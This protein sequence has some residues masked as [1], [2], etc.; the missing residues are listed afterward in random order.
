MDCWGG[1]TLGQLGNGTTNDAVR[2]VSAL[3]PGAG[4]TAIAANGQH[5]CAM[6][7]D[8]TV[9]CWGANYDG[10]NGNGYRVLSTTPVGVAGLSGTT[11]TAVS[12]D[13]WHSCVL[14]SAG[15]VDCWGYNSNG[16]LG[17]GT[18]TDSSTPG[19]VS[20]P[21]TG[22]LSGVTAIDAGEYYNCALLSDTT[23]DCW[24]ANYDGQLGNNSTTDSSKPVAVSGLT[25]VTAIS[26][27]DEFTCA[28]LGTGAVW[29]WG[30]NFYGQ[31][32]NGSTTDSH[33]PVQVTGI[34]TATA[35]TAGGFHA[36]AR[37]SD[38]AVQC[39][40][41]NFDGQLGNG[42]VADHEATPVAVSGLANATAIAG[43]TYTTCALA[44]THRCVFSSP[45]DTDSLRAQPD[46]GRAD[47]RRSEARLRSPIVVRALSSA[48]CRPG[49]VSRSPISLRATSS[50]PAAF[51][52]SRSTWEG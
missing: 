42:T 10:E 38:G 25:G 21:S 11:V 9:Y 12:V 46:V 34:T 18:T 49:S 7:G 14:L 24:G 40:G 32:G 50:R 27:G 48:H 37:L 16:Q 2:P 3:L 31:L 51:Q 45:L 43:G 26:A 39:W 52:I 47:R 13:G 41:A 28:L 5:S 23:V 22:I 17:K 36:C 19:Q 29:C 4:A 8:G 33:V 30:W 15:T 20:G 44:G 6:Y 35:I 1:N